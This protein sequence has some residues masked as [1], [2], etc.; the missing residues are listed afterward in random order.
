MPVISKHVF[1]E[2]I[3]NDLR[4]KDL[5]KWNDNCLIA[6]L[7]FAQ[8]TFLGAL[9]FFIP[10]YIVKALINHKKMKQ[11]KFWI[12]LL[13]EEFRSSLYGA[14]LA[15]PILTGNCL[16]YNLTGHIHYYNIALI[17]G[18]VSA[19]ALLI[20]TKENKMLDTLI[21]FNVMVESILRNLDHFNLMKMTNT[22]QTILFMLTAALLMSSLQNREE[23]FKFP[24]FWFYTPEKHI[25]RNSEDSIPKCEHDDS[26]TGFA[27]KG[28]S[29]Y[30]LLGS[31]FSIA[32][33]LIPNMLS[34]FQNPK[35]VFPILVNTEH[36]TFGAFIGTFVGIYRYVFCLLL[37]TNKLEQKYYGAV[38]GF[39]SGSAYCLSPNLQVLAVGITTILQLEYNK[40][41]QKHKIKYKGVLQQIIYSIAH[42]ILLHNAFAC[43]ETCPKYY[44][45]MLNVGSGN[46]YTDIY[47][48]IVGK[49]F[50]DI[51]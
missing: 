50:S 29:K 20:E 10:I 44:V 13:Q 27:L 51:S 39:L 3:I 2:K 18:L 43:R 42:S 12:K 16:I 36:V 48:S 38:A 25:K 7:W 35:S 8:K 23:N 40:L 4:C 32:K 31:S 41:L 1:D 28:I 49:Y 46:V 30:F 15:Q 33:K 11:K 19:F 9:K 21:F 26:C 24:H 6:N 47:N 22:N 17:N 14:L 45:N 34:I 37:T 5:H